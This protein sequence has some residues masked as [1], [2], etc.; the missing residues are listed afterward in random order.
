MI[1]GLKKQY[2]MIF[3]RG[4]GGVNLIMET[5]HISPVNENYSND[6]RK[7]IENACHVSC[8]G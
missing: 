8:V 1:E 5:R 4:G 2:W 7:T 6:I 3:A